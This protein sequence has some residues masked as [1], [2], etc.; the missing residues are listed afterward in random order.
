[1]QPCLDLMMSAKTICPE[2][3][4][5]KRQKKSNKTEPIISHNLSTNYEYLVCQEKNQDGQ[6]ILRK[7]LVIV[8]QKRFYVGNST[9]VPMPTGCN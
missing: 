1:M 4:T 8:S 3:H 5:S 7:S 9:A 6:G 2:L